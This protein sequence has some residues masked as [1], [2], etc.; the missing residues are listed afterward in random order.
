MDL[1]APMTQAEFG[2]L[3]GVSHQAVSDLA[4]RGILT[5]NAPAREN[6][7]A[8]CSHIREIAAGRYAAGD[9]DL[10][11]ERAA[12]ARE[13]RIRIA[14]QNSVTRRELA[15]VAL[16]EEVLARAG[17]KVAGILDAIPGMLRR[18]LPTLTADDLK[19]VAV[20]IAR[21]RNIAAAVS[22]ADLR[23]DEETAPEQDE[24]P[25]PDLESAAA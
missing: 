1:T 25:S 7:L 16:I 8:Y 4:N 15:P 24:A 19:I 5:P 14:M 21:A 2:A 17:S 9:L 13:Q 10:A 6:L 22:L 23:D 20:E 3:I 11:T 18:R 12:L